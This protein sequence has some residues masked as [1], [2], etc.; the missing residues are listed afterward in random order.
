MAV[1]IGAPP[2]VVLASQSK[3]PSNKEKY[4]VSS[5]IRGDAKS[6]GGDNAD[7]LEL[8]KLEY[9]GL[10]V[11]K[12]SELVLE[13]ESIPNSLYNDT[14]F[15]EYPGTYSFRSNSWLLKVKRIHHRSDYIY[16]TILTGKLPQE[17]S[18]LCG[19]PYASEIYKSASKLAKVTDI[20]SFLG[21]NVFDTIVCI[22]KE[23]NEQIQ[24]LLYTLLGNK[25]LKSVT[26]MDNDLKANEK[27]FRFAFNTRYQ[28]DRDTI[29]TGLAL[30][31]SLDPS[32]PLFQSTS[33]IGF[34]MTV[35]HG[36]SV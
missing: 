15:G 35:P 28:P 26:I 13:C 29:I 12:N 19:I 17:D 9:S 3:I 23:S 1:V 20:S 31:A 8:V 32:S 27:D 11:P 2:E 24:N 14:P 21:N 36:K 10:L 34:D 18:N 5:H 16:Q 4:L 33:K 30:G 25:Y 7:L 6:Y 22:K